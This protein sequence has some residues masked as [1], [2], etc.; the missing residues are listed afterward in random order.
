[1]T[2]RRSAKKLRVFEAFS[3]IGAQ[4]AALKSLGIDY[5]IV[6]TSDWFVNAILAYD[7]I[8]C[9][10]VKKKIKVPDIE[11]QIQ[12]LE[13]FTFSIDS[14]T[15]LKSVRKLKKDVI[16]K[17][18]IAQ[19]RTKNFGSITDLDPASL[20]E[21]DVLVYSFPCQDLSTGGNCTG[22]GEGS[23]TRSCM[24]W[25]VGRILKA[26][27]ELNRLPK[28]LLMENVPAIALPRYAEDFGRWKS[29][30]AELG[31]Q[32]EEPFVLNATQFGV[33]QNRSR[34]FMFSH[35]GEKRGARKAK[36]A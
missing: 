27:K 20:P 31:Y 34:L 22:M 33:P 28:Y 13:N 3:G 5:E 11:E 21:M 17:L 35:L 9:S 19:K 4:N 30:L 36:R 25:H 26:L 8:H 18:Y 14:Q 15:A 7:A 23:G 10:K 12:F 2:K 29:L 6:G 16:E 1:M 24:I 32:N